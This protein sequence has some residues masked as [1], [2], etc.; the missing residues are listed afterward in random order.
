MKTR[1]SSKELAVCAEAA[2]R[3]AVERAQAQKIPY[4]VQE[5]RKIV[6]HFPNGNKEVT[7]TLPK[8]YVKTDSKRFRVS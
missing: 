6:K 2:S 3:R 7:H 8:A 1:I 5:G 4:T